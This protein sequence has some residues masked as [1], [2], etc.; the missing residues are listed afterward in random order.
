[1]TPS[2]ADLQALC[3][4]A[5]DAPWSFAHDPQGKGH[6]LT[7]I[8]D[9]NGMFVC[10]VEQDAGSAEFI[11]AARTAL[12]ELLAR[13]RQLEAVLGDIRYRLDEALA[14]PHGSHCD[15]KLRQIRSRVTEAIGTRRMP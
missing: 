15:E 9:G 12:P 2:L 14:S 7:R 4:A 1:M 8:L 13:V 3:D 6:V 11:A 5:I 10:E